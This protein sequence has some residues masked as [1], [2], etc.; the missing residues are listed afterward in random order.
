ML[1][2][3][4]Q[5]T[6]NEPG[7]VTATEAYRINMIQVRQENMRVTVLK[8]SYDILLK[9]RLLFKQN[10]TEMMINFIHANY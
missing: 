9:W 7:Q 1:I 5:R 8:A 10:W 6:E 4:E 3:F 2:S